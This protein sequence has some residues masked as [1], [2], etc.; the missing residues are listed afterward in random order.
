MRAAIHALFAAAGGTADAPATAGTVVHTFPRAT[1]PSDGGALHD[2][3]RDRVHEDLFPLARECYSAALARKPKLAG[4]LVVNFTIVGDTRVGG[5]VDSAEIDPTS[6][7]V[8]Q[9]M[10][11]CV[12]ESMMSVAF[13]APPEGRSL[14][15]VTYPIEFSPDDAPDGA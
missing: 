3:I 4:K 11:T 6:N 9:E 13:D 14:V 12:K 8:D 15:T 10:S 2:Y 5:V 1:M 7:L